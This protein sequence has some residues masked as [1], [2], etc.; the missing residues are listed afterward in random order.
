MPRGRLGAPLLTATAAV[1]TAA[2]AACQGG[3]G[4]P[5]VHGIGQLARELDGAVCQLH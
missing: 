1:L 2:L 3:N 5:A 4:A